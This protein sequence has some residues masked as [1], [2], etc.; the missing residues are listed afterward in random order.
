MP[1]SKS[2]AVALA[3]LAALAACGGGSP[4]DPPPRAT[5]ALVPV[6]PGEL[7]AYAQERL[8]A[9]GGGG[10]PPGVVAVEG[11]QPAPADAVAAA[12]PPGTLVQEPGIDE[13]DRLKLAD[14]QVLSLHGGFLRRHRL[15]AGA[16][17]PIDDLPL[18]T[19]PA[20][21]P[22]DRTLHVDADGRHA[23]VL[24]QQWAAAPW[25]GPCLAEVC[26]QLTAVAYVPT[27][28]RLRLLP[29][30]LGDRM[31]AG[32]ALT[33][34]GR[35]V[36]SRRVGSTLVLVTTH[37]PALALDALPA[38]A[39]PAEREAMLAA[40]TA[41]DL[42]PQL[43]RGNAAP[44]PLVTETDCL[45]QPGNASP[46]LQV[47]TVTVLDLSASDPVPRSRCIVGGTEALYMSAESL[48]LATTRWP[49]DQGGAQP[50]YAADM[51]TDVHRFVLEGGVPAY[52]ASGSVPGHLGW[53]PARR[54]HR[55]S[56]WQGH[57]RVLSF[58][59]REGWAAA[60]AAATAPSPATLSVLREEAG[61]LRTV[62]QLPNASRPAPLGK[63]DE[64]VYAVRFIGARG[65][66]VTFRQTDPLYVLDLADPA[67]PRAAGVLEVPGFSQDLVE[68]GTGWLLGAGREADAQG[69]VTGLAFSLFDVRDAA[70]P[71]LQASARLGG[72]GS[73]SALDVSPQ[74]L[75]LWR[76]GAGARAAL[77]VALSLDG[78]PGTALQRITLD[79]A[80]GTMTLS[81]LLAAP[82]P[83]AGHGGIAAERALVLGDQ[84]LYL[85]GSGGLTLHAW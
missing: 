23:L 60:P 67:D 27:V 9:R 52:R 76:D 36:G 5:A 63:P 6:Q 11:G 85:D 71:R 7:L 25:S 57:L 8:R 16:L 51:Q 28:P 2:L 54:A 22:G 1:P 33:L 50:V 74:G 66:V 72:G 34:D 17:T 79:T 46:M 30:S 78:Q 43:R 55:F 48:V 15:A 73:S 62:G 12:T 20:A 3:T 82:P 24:D 80:A 65:Y 64:Q 56:E 4:A 37:L 14:D 44:V 38:G 18:A 70:N 32:P 68:V 13:A 53:D 75:S 35:L 31:A 61:S 10:L 69:L 58:T 26:T 40:L 81:P 47:T 39:A 83:D 29:V 41:N 45:L 19:D 77:P 21:L 49:L 42:L 84:V 59:G